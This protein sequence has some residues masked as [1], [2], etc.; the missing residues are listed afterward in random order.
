MS[1]KRGFPEIAPWPLVII[2]F[3]VG[4]SRGVPRLLQGIHNGPQQLVQAARGLDTKVVPIALLMARS[5][6]LSVAGTWD[7]KTMGT[8]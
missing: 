7:G 8:W 2:H 1:Y 5:G 3:R 4:F 6:S